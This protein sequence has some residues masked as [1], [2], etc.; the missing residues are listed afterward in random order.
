MKKSTKRMDPHIRL[1][2][3]IDITEK[4][5]AMIVRCEG[6]ARLKVSGCLERHAVRARS[7]SRRV[8]RAAIRTGKRNLRIDAESVPRW[9]MVR[10]LAARISWRARI[11]NRIRASVL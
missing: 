3:H 2:L 9:H 11:G 10:T 8:P 4:V 6:P 5:T 7:A 1:A